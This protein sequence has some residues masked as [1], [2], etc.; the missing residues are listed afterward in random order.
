MPHNMFGQK[1]R[2]RVKEIEFTMEIA[3]DRG[4]WDQTCD[5]VN[6]K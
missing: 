5:K 1:L 3:I 2:M 6:M 4:G